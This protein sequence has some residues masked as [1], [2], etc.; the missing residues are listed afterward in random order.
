MFRL[1]ITATRHDIDPEFVWMPLWQMV[2]KHEALVIVHGDCPTGG[3]ALAQQ[4]VDLPGQQWN[5][6]VKGRRNG[7]E[8]ERLVIAERHPANWEYYGKWAGPVRNQEMVT[9]GADACFA[10]PADD[11]R[12]TYDCMAR[13]YRAGIPIWRWS[14]TRLGHGHRVTD[15]EGEA[16]VQRFLKHD[17]AVAQ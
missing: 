6:G 12:G 17:K 16:L 8:V 13:A 5:T 7:H 3:D 9:A 2:H 10:W 15:A 1:L 14:L 4:W 11:S